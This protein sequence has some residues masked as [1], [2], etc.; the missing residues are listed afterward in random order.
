MLAVDPDHESSVSRY[1][2]LIAPEDE[3]SSESDP[4]D[5]DEQPPPKP[6]GPMENALKIAL[7]DYAIAVRKCLMHYSRPAHQATRADLQQRKI[8]YNHVPRVSLTIIRF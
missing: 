3:E 5:E 6:L 4:E 1:R 8:H 2:Q 7:L